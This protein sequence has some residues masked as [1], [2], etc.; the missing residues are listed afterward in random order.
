VLSQGQKSAKVHGGFG[1]VLYSEEGLLK[2]GG[3]FPGGM[4]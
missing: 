3:F 2:G 1:G 4:A